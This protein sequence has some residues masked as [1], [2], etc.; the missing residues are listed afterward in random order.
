MNERGER[1]GQRGGP[2]LQVRGLSVSLGR[3]AVPVLSDVHFTAGARE[4]V[5]VVGET[6]SGKTTLARAVLGL[7]R[8]DRGTVEVDGTTV[9]ALRGRALREHRRRGTTQYVFQDPLRSLDPALTLAASVGEALTIRGVPPAERDERVRAAL[10][11]VGLSPDL[12]ER[13]PGQVSGGQRQRAAIARA[14]ICEPR[15]LLCDEPVSALDAA[16]RNHVL[17]LLGELRATLGAAIV[18]ISHDLVSLA[19]VADRVAV[20]Y[21]GRIVEQGP[22]R[23]VFDD[24]RHPYTALLVASAPRV[25]GRRRHSLDVLR[26]AAPGEPGGCVY[27]ARCPFATAACAAVPATASAGDRSVACHHA[28]DWPARTAGRTPLVAEGARP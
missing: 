3:P 9:S 4:I 18:V 10:E 14:V 22:I 16:H 12:G 26:R 6:G 25:T 24:P 8:P 20:L 21:R 1:A 5:G 27:A 28:D 19:G 23:E 11:L 2:L 7:V 17:R 13:T 15:V